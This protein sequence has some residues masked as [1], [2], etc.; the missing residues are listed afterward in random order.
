MS[1][2]SLDASRPSSARRVNGLASRLQE[3][4]HARRR[5]P[6]S[7]RAAAL[8]RYRPSHSTPLA[9]P[10]LVRH[11]GGV[12]YITGTATFI[13]CVFKNNEAV[14]R[15]KAAALARCRPSHSTPLASP[16]PGAS[17]LSLRGCREYV[18]RAGARRR[19]I[20]PPRSRDVAR[21]SRRFPPLLRSCIIREASHTSRARPRFSVAF[22]K[23]MKR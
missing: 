3:V 12:A 23:T 9:S 18:T 19:A 10:A 5:A 7:D 22:S 21:L 8:A 20:A 13:D 15:L 1:P 6:P 14:R 17:T 16:V 11:Q 2:I 4:R